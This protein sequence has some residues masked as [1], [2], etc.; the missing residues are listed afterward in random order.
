MSL[1]VAPHDIIGDDHIVRLEK[2]LERCRQG[3]ILDWAMVFIA[4]DGYGC[5]QSMRDPKKLIICSLLDLAR[6]RILDDFTVD[7]V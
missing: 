1:S 4:K 6:Q 5:S 3:E 7:Y 2:I